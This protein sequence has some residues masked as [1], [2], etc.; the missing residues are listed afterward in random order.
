MQKENAL[1]VPDQLEPKLGQRR[2][3]QEAQGTLYL[4]EQQNT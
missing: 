4:A 1:T 2:L 3:R